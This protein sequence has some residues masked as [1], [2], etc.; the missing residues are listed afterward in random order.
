MTVAGG[1][2]MNVPRWTWTGAASLKVFA[3]S[4]P[5]L[6]GSNV[7]P[8]LVRYG[9]SVRTTFGLTT[10]DTAVRLSRC[11][12]RRYCAVTPVMASGIGL[13]VTVV[14]SGAEVVP[15]VFVAVIERLITSD[16][17]VPAARVGAVNDTVAEVPDT[18]VTERPMSEAGFCATAKVTLWPCGSVAVTVKLARAPENTE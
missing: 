18:G 10:E 17:V 7:A 8:D 5:R 4:A 12:L 3:K 6:L 1:N 11:L 15:P 14:W 9:W 16:A 2:A 13:T